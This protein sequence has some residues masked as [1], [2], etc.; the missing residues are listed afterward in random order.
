MLIKKGNLAQEVKEKEL[1]LKTSLIQEV[2]DEDLEINLL[3]RNGFDD[4]RGYSLSKEIALHRKKLMGTID[5][6]EWNAY[7]AYVSLCIE[8][9]REKNG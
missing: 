3:I 5:D 2:T 8:K 4:Y 6:D 1:D 9:A 7:T